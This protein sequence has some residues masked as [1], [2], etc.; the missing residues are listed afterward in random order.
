MSHIWMSHVTHM[1]ES[2]HTYE[3]VMSHIWM[4]HVTNMNESCHTY[5]CVMS[6][7]WMSHVTHMNESCQTYEWVMSHIWMTH[8]GLL[9]KKDNAPV[10]ESCHTYECVMSHLLM[11]HGAHMKFL[12]KGFFW[13]F[14]GHI[15]LSNGCFDQ[16]RWAVCECTHI[17]TPVQR[18]P[19]GLFCRILSL[20]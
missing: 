14:V 16:Y 6:H 10:P 15:N 2:C 20:L 1:N 3:W 11:T 13:T 4:R 19:R 7:I 5:E 12:V 18:A 8:S 9:F 17:S